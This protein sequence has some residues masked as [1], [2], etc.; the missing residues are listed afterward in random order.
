MIEYRTGMQNGVEIIHI[1]GVEAIVG[2]GV[3]LSPFVFRTQEELAEP[4]LVSRLTEKI[5]T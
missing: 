1:V 5:F 4:R 2:H 3:L